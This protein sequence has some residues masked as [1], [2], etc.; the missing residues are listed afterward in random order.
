[1]KKKKSMKTASLFLSLCVLLTS[2]PAFPALANSARLQWTGTDR[3]G[4]IITDETCPVTVEREQ[5]TFDIQE[6]PEQSYRKTEDYLAYGS[7]VTAEYTF[8]NPAD[9]AVNAVLVF[10]FGKL[11]DYGTVYDE[12]KGEQ[13]LPSDTEK[14]NITV[15]GAEIQKNLRHTFAPFGRQFD[16]EKD[17]DLL[18]QGYME[19]EFY[20]P[21]MPVTRYTYVSSG[22]DT[23]TWDA[24]SAAFIPVF[25]PSETKILM[26]NQNGLSTLED[27]VQ[28]ESWVHD[29]PF[30][31]NVI[32]RP[33]K[34]MPEWKFYEN[35]ACEKEIEGTM[36]LADTEVLTLEE[37]VLSEYQEDSGILKHD[38]YNAMIEAM[39]YFE[40][41]HGII[42]SSENSF[43]L[44]DISRE[45]MRWYEYE[46]V[47]EPGERLKNTVTAP[48]YPSFNAAYEPPV[49][50]YTY[51]LSP[52]QS[53]KDF[54][55][56][57]IAVNTPYYMVEDSL[58]QFKQDDS[59]FT[60]HL[61][62][63]PEGELTFTLCRERKPLKAA[64]RNTVTAAVIFLPLA[65]VLAIAIAVVIWK[66]K[67]NE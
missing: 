58:G 37:F 47:L 55:P 51:L 49:Y 17:M 33:L 61:E 6:F 12:E 14:Y 35:G 39:K 38:W 53:W 24:A 41:S 44:F 56:L 34:Q 42:D 30:T 21:D 11:P 36:T 20:T 54:G 5:L 31:V 50:E 13:V 3:T 4:A 23:E 66:K 1:M 45:L 67:R 63:L 46:L 8:Y 65:A 48:V 9:Y 32:G 27:A 60:C 28:L 62:G 10:P 15:N 18:H 26:E 43:E 7:R 64:N 40:V 22:V 59:G 52:A 25:D 57:D 2:L 29:E 19:D 16:K